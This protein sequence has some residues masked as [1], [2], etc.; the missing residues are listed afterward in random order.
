M[1]LVVYIF[2]TSGR[3]PAGIGYGMFYDILIFPPDFF[4]QKKRDQTGRLLSFFRHEA[5]YRIRSE[6]DPER[7]NLALNG[8]ICLIDIFLILQYILTE[9]F[10]KVLELKKSWKEL[11]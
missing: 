2:W 4:K 1:D 11:K 9:G 10:L 8:K 3:V 5:F 7:K 6:S